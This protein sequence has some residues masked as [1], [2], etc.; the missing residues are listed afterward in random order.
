MNKQSTDYI[1]ELAALFMF[2]I[3]MSLFL[4]EKKASEQLFYSFERSYMNRDSVYEGRSEKHQEEVK[5]SELVLIAMNPKNHPVYFE[6]KLYLQEEEIDI[7]K[8]KL[9]KEYIESIILDNK[10]EITAVVYE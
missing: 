5:G 2:I 9:D 7:S 3:A 6:G 4:V 10:G 8:I 1:F